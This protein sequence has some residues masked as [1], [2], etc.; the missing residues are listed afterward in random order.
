MPPVSPVTVQVYA[1]V[2]EQ[3]FPSGFDVAVY[4]VMAEVPEEAGAVQERTACRTPAVAV[5]AVGAS[6]TP[7]MAVGVTAEEAADGAPVPAEFF[8]VT[9][10]V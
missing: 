8:A 5:T 7:E 4:P 1:P 3:V 9:V 2:V 6:G 10:N